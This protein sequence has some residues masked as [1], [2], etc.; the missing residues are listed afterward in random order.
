MNLFLDEDDYILS[1][2]F[3]TLFYNVITC[4]ADGEV[5]P[6]PRSCNESGT[7]ERTAVS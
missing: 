4:I 3:V 2:A 1:F 6:D 5:E 7:Q